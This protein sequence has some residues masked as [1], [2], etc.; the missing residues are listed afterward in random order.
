MDKSQEFYDR[1]AAALAAL[2]GLRT[3]ELSGMCWPARAPVEA[4]PWRPAHLPLAPPPAGHVPA[5]A[6]DDAYDFFDYLP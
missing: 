6:A 2:P 1:T 4:S 5:P 3:F